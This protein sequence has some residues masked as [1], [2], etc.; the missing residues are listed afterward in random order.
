MVRTCSPAAPLIDGCARGAALTL[1][2]VACA[3]AVSVA[4]ADLRIIAPNA[5]KEIVSDA[6]ARYQSTSASATVFTWSGSE[7][8][9]KRVEE[10]EVF[11]V[12]LNTPQNLD[13]LAKAG[14]IVPGTRVDFAKSGIGIA[15][16]AGQ[17][18]PDISNEEALRKALL[19]AKS[20]GLSSGPS[21]RYMAKVFQRLGIADQVQGKI[22]QPPSG[23][24]I[25]ELLSR[26][27]VELGFQQISELQHAAGV[28]YLGPLPAGLQSYTIWSGGVHSATN[29]AAAARIFLNALVSSDS[30]TAIRK[31][32]MDPM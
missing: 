1:A 9:A 26:G 18:R 20:I 4:G 19:Q 30:A 5:V 7:A 11:D 3:F 13:M 10:G 22:R 16:R 14:K 31:A 24:Q 6:A 21:G 2:I 12:V 28:E 29:E 32:G 23:A 25:A 8:I 17:S 27:E 15:V